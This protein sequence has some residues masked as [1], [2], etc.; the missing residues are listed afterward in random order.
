MQKKQIKSN[1]SVK[2]NNY[3]TLKAVGVSEA[4]KSVVSRQEKVI[5]KPQVRMQPVSKVSKQC[6]TYLAPDGLKSTLSN[7]SF[8]NNK[9]SSFKDFSKGAE[10][11]PDSASGSS[12][13]GQLTKWP[14]NP[15]PS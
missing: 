3:D 5:R 2:S 4:S 13:E 15:F 12:F 14:T 7:A 1:A 11:I 9:I 10:V 8:M 6:Y